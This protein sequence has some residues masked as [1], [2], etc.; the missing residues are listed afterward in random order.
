VVECGRLNRDLEDQVKNIWANVR[1]F[2]KGMSLKEIGVMS[3][4]NQEEQ[5]ILGKANEDYKSE[6][7]FIGAVL[8]KIEMYESDYP[9]QPL[10]QSYFSNIES[11]SS[12]RGWL[13]NEFKG[14]MELHGYEYKR[15]SHERVYVKRN[16]AEKITLTPSLQ[17]AINQKDEVW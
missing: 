3:A 14:F 2:V 9:G 16:G 12:Y 6:H 8:E 1:D 7:T 4:W 13:K 17:R 10:K 15:L 5:E 11:S